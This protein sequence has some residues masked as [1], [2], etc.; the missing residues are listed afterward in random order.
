MGN[1]GRSAAGLGSPG[2]ACGPRA[3]MGCASGWSSAGRRGGTRPDVGR[4][5][6]SAAAARAAGRRAGPGDP[7]PL[8]GRPT[9][10]LRPATRMGPARTCGDTARSAP[11]RACAILGRSSRGGCTSASGR[12]DGARMGRASGGTARARHAVGAVMEPARARSAPMGGSTPSRSRTGRH[13][14]LGRTAF[15]GARRAGAADGRTCM[16]RVLSR[17]AE[18]A[19]LEPGLESS[20]GASMGPAEDRRARSPRCAF[21]VGA[22]R[23]RGRGLRHPTAVDPSASLRAATRLCVAGSAGF[24]TGSAA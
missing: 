12:A 3:D 13:Q 15:R 4:A 17:A 20:G 22:G 8:V 14:R 7:R 10:N 18:R 6:S 24:G 23:A 2:F 1:A 16:G 9:S 19:R 5:A 11:R 21:V